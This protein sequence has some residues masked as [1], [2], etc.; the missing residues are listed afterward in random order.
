[1][2]HPGYLTF[3]RSEDNEPSARQALTRGFNVAVPFRDPPQRF[4]GHPV[5]DGDTHDYRFLDQRP[6]VVG[7]K[8]KGRARD[9]TTGF[10]R[11]DCPRYV[12]GPGRQHTETLPLWA[13]FLLMRM[14]ILKRNPRS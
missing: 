8:P 12:P 11:E 3:S 14:S 1:M 6:V 5:I 7:L 10:V 2:N 4:L 9:D 13:H